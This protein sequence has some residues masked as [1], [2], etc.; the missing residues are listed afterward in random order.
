MIHRPTARAGRIVVV[1]PAD[2]GEA[3]LAADLVIDL[4]AT[5]KKSGA[6]LIIDQ[7]YN[8]RLLKPP[9]AG[10]YSRQNAMLRS[11]RVAILP[12]TMSID[13]SQ[14]HP[15]IICTAELVDGFLPRIS[16]SKMLG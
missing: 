2:A 12:T 14:N 6:Q 9:S 16:Y 1:P 4:I 11:L 3:I 15:Q 7:M 13:T 5:Q 10:N 8:L